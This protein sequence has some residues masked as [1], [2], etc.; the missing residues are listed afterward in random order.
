MTLRPLVFAA[1][2][3]LALLAPALCPA[4][5]PAQTLAQ[6][7]AA[8]PGLAAPAPFSLDALAARAAAIA[9]A[10]Y[11]PAPP[12]QPEV[13][14]RIDYDAHWQIRYRK[15]KTL[16]LGAVPV[17]FFH[18]GTY[19]RQPVKMFAVANGQAREVLYAPALFDMPKDS[20]ARDLTADAGFAGFRIL[21]PDL[22]GD[23]ISF[24]GATYF[25]TEGALGQFGLSARAIAVDTGLPS[26]EEFP[27]FTE[28]Y[29]EEGAG[30]QAVVTALVEGRSLAGVWRMAI[31]N[32]PGQGQVMAVESRIYL[33]KPVARLGLAPLTSMCWYSETN[34]WHALDWRPEVH[35]S[36]G[37][38]IAPATGTP[39]WRA[40]D[41]PGDIVTTLSGKTVEVYD[42][43]CEGRMVLADILYLAASRHKPRVIVDL[44][45]LTYSV[46]Q[47]LGHV[48]AGLFATDDD[49]AAELLAAGESVGERF[50]RLP[51]DPAYEVELRTPLADLRQHAADLHDGD[52]PHA[53]AFL[54]QFTCG[55]RWAH[56]DIA[57]KELAEKDLPLAR[58]GGT[59]FGVRLLEEW[60]TEVAQA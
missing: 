35:D 31:T 40:L 23:W 38:L 7:S 15:D 37:L 33:R 10:P 59:G 28:V 24:L 26:G 36:D 29:L 2:A 54:R 1:T 51:L 6:T 22:S 42:T 27:R 55:C 14:E 56:L 17:Q 41:T 25:R 12:R 8:G 18:L 45:T 21:R 47:G 34:R 19:F 57:G 60:I 11:V 58:R 32:T 4:E 44:A 39:V 46:M 13:L 16:Q 50:W 43:D 20:P 9:R 52:A 30:G 3:A 53:A 5:T 49:L 48:F